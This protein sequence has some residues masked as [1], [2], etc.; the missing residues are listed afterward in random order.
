[1][2]LINF[3]EDKFDLL[4][5][6]SAALEEAFKREVYP[7]GHR[8]FLPGSYSNKVLFIEKGLIRTYYDKD[9]KDITHFFSSENAFFLPIE[10]VFYNKPTNFGLELLEPCVLRTI[11]YPDLEK[12]IAT[13]PVIEKL[14]RI[15][16]IDVLKSFSERVVTLQFQSAYEKYKTMLELHPD[17][18]L[19][20]PLGHIAS[21]L[22]ITA[23]TLSVIRAQK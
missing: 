23:Q 10:C 6:V 20:A 1:M 17:I 15:L 22:G 7:K 4:P 21:Y 18:L 19:R 12:H 9:N 14:M 2:D 13:Y 8:L 11:Q 5:D 3:L 16:F